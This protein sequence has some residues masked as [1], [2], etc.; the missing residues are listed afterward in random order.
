VL[1]RKRSKRKS[2]RLA[3]LFGTSRPPVSSSSS[4]QYLAVDLDALLIY[5]TK[6]YIP[7]LSTDRQAEFRLIDKKLEKTETEAT[8]ETEVVDDE[9]DE[10]VCDGKEESESGSSNICYGYGRPYF[11]DF[12][13]SVLE[14]T[15]D[16]KLKLVLCMNVSRQ[17]LVNFVYLLMHGRRKMKMLEKHL[18]HLCDQ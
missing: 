18:F 8:E 3:K 4:E 14:T 2:E 16:G 17:V 5:R 11:D 12:L 7:N 6:A 1:F 9:E 10:K 15:S 13:K